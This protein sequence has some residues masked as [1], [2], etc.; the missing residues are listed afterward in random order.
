MKY[1]ETIKREKTLRQKLMPFF[2]LAVAAPVVLFACLSMYRLDRSMQASLDRQIKGNLSKS[3]QC[4]DMVFD[5]YDTLLKELCSDEAFIAAVDKNGQKGGAKDADDSSIY[6]ELRHMCDQDSGIEGITII[7]AAGRTMYYDRLSASSENSSW[8][9]QVRAPYMEREPVYEGVA[10]PVTASS[11]RVYMLRIA[12]QLEDMKDTGRTV[13]TAVLSINENLLTDALDA[14]DISENYLLQDGVVISAPDDADIGKKMDE[15]RTGD[16]RYTSVVNEVSGFTICNKQPLKAYHDTFT[17][18]SLIWL[19]IMAAVV[20]AV[21]VLGYVMTR[22]YL[23]EIDRIAGAM[24][25]VERGNFHAEVEVN[26]RT[27]VEIRKISSGFNQMVRQIEKLIEQVKAAVLEQKNAELSAL[28]AQIDPHFLYNTLDTINWKAIE[29]GEF[30]ISEMVGALADILRYTVKN[31]GEETSIEQ[32]LYWLRQ[33]ILLQSAKEGKEIQMQFHVPENLRGCRIHKLLL[34]PFVENSIRHGMRH[35]EGECRVDIS[36]HGTGQ[37]IHIII[38]DNGNGIDADTLDRLNSRDFE[39]DRKYA[40]RHL[41][42]TN[43]RKRLKLYYGEQADIYF[44][45]RPPE[46][47]KVH[48][49]IPA[50]RPGKEDCGD[51]NRSC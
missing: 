44:E 7:T 3:E 46:Y 23:N 1:T 28:E 14:W 49:F 40:E 29:K 26:E 27:P 39:S 4:L 12:R 19:L 30:E 17:E 8:A 10:E 9:A 18:Q 16:Y 6:E 31:A 2:F 15:I 11:G 45:S 35:K 5:K 38:A 33:Y 34:Q 32:E 43:V 22:P 25:E 47:T 41:G 42:I 37:Q 51:E 21:F 20:V 48:L 13:G 24:S 36:M 50:V